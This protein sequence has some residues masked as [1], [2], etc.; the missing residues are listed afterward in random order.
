YV[1]PAQS[2][3]EGPRTYEYA[4]GVE[5]LPPEAK[6]ILPHP[7]GIELGT[8]IQMLERT[9]SAQ[10]GAFFKEE[11]S[12]VSPKVA[13]EICEH[14]GLTERTPVGKVGHD[15]AERLFKAIQ[16]VKIM[17]PPTDCLS[18]IGPRTLIKGLQ[19][20]L[21]P[22]FIAVSSRPPAVYRGRPF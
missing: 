16:E 17:T 2:G 18:P 4:R 1:A 19:K 20:G 6:E 13:K 10:L 22:D 21:K 15:E 11:F 3:D 14:A 12:R 7:H 5:E 9:R 8:L